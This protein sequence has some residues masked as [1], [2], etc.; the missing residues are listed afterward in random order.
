M[1]PTPAEPTTQLRMDHASAVQLAAD[2]ARDLAHRCRLPGFLPDQAAVLASELASNLVKHAKDGALYLQPQPMGDGLEILAADHGPGMA[3]LARCLSDGYSTT[4][5]LGAGLGAVRRIAG[6]FV[7][8][9]AAGHGTVAYARLAPPGGPAPRPPAVGALSL[10]ADSEEECGDACAFADTDD[11][12]TALVADGL[13]HGPQAADAA[14]RA[15]STFREAHDAPLPELL[16]RVHRA[17]RGTRGAA[18]GLL[19]V[20]PGRAEYCGVGNIRFLA[21]FPH[22]IRHRST[23]QPGIVG[24]NIPRPVVRSLPLPA[25]TV[26]VLHSDGIAAR[27]ADAPTPFLLRLPP[28]LLA[29][30]LIHGHRYG[31]D[32]AA[33]LAGRVPRER[34]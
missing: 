15:V 23:G 26:L 29:A 21:V 12:R 24:W 11:A 18:V 27:W 10:P 7:I 3:E 6:D 34:R 16:T 4:R 22:E 20:R 30:A 1:T 9:S 13:G 8:R 33:V 5:S 19:R 31:N 17:L 32:D 25:E 2:T 14:A 28:P